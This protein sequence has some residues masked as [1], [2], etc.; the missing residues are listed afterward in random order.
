MASI[1]GLNLKFFLCPLTPVLRHTHTSS[2]TQL[3]PLQFYHLPCCPQTFQGR[4]CLRAFAFTVTSPCNDLPS[5]AFMASFSSSFMPLLKSPPYSQFYTT[6]L[7][8]HT[9]GNL[10][11]LL[12]FKHL[13]TGIY[14]TI[15]FCLLLLFHYLTVSPMKGGRFV[16]FI[17]YCIHIT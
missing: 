4:S 15:L 5:D 16:C 13:L 8:D 11:H 10:C 3:T 2:N 7:H 12:Y 6:S 14:F 1:S 17:H 9:H